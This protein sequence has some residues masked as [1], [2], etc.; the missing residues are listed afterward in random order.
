[1]GSWGGHV[2]V[3]WGSW[4][5]HGVMWCHVV[6]VS[7]DLQNGVLSALPYLGSGLL[8]VGGGQLADYLRDARQYR[9]V[10]VRKAFSLVG[11][12]THPH[13]HPPTHPHTHPLI[14]S[15]IH[16]RS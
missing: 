7:C 5:G 10:V 11:E 16:S 4:G 8:A 6:M 9:T 2:T 12:T 15:I 14:H 1:M 3:I 13:N